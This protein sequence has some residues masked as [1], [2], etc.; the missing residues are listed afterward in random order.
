MAESKKPATPRRPRSTRS[1]PPSRGNEYGEYGEGEGDE[2]QESVAAH[3]LF[4]ERHFGGGAPASAEMLDRA[5]AVW[6]RLPGAV[7]G[8]AG[9]VRSSDPGPI[10]DPRSNDEPS[11][12]GG[13]R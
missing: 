7:A 10:A 13:P 1:A 2:G 5:N 4:V 9:L 3:A 12:S 6:R 8:G 11:G